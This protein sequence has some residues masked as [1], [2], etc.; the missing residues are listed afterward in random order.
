MDSDTPPKLSKYIGV[1]LNTDMWKG[2]SNRLICFHHTRTL[3]F[4]WSGDEAPPK[5]LWYYVP[6]VY[7]FEYFY[8]FLSF[9]CGIAHIHATYVIRV[10]FGWSFFIRLS[11]VS[12][13]IW[14]IYVSDLSCKV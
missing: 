14:V 6:Y 10:L 13:M 11:N 4:M 3:C 12:V 5:G 8:Y 2:G 1:A 7:Y 9:L